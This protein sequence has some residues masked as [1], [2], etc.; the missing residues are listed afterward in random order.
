MDHAMTLSTAAWPHGAAIT[1]FKRAVSTN[2]NSAI[3]K[4][5]LGQA[6]LS[7][8]WVDRAIEQLCDALRLKDNYLD[9][10]VL[11]FLKYTM[12]AWLQT[13]RLNHA[14]SLNCPARTL[15]TRSFATSNRPASSM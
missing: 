11:Q 3:A 14:G 12:K 1:R 4:N 13:L 15:I 6:W 7:K 2:P 5:L 10:L 9:V 8:D